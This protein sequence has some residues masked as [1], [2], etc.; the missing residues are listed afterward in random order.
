M[1]GRKDLKSGLTWALLP[2]LLALPALPA[3]GEEKRLVHGAALRSDTSPPLRELISKIPPRPTGLSVEIPLGARPGAPTLPLP[4]PAASR[5]EEPEI[6]APGATL[7]PAVLLSFPGLSDDDNSA[8][9]GG[10]F[11][12]PDTNGDIGFDH[13]GNKIYIQYINKIWG[14]F[15]PADGTLIFGPTIGNTFWSGFGGL[16]QTSNS[17]DTLVLYDDDAGRWVFA[18]FVW[19]SGGLVCVAVSA[20]G[21]PLGSY[22]RYAFQVASAGGFADYPKLGVWAQGPQGPGQGSVPTQSAYT[23]TTRNF[24]WSQ[25]SNFMHTTVLERDRMLTGSAAKF[26]S[27]P[28][29][30]TVGTDCL[31]GQLPPHQ[32][33]PP[34]PWGTCPTFFAIVDKQFDDTLFA[35]DGVRLERLCV[36]WQN[37]ANSTITET[38]LPS[39][40]G[41]SRALGDGVNACISPVKSPGE[42]L[43]CLTVFTMYRAQYRYFDGSDGNGAHASVVVNTTVDAGSQRAGIHWLELRSADGQSAWSIHQQGTYAPADARERWMGSIAQDGMRN[44]ALG[45]SRVSSSEFPSLYY[46]ARELGDAAGAMGS[47]ERCHDGTGVQTASFER[48]GDYSAM[49]VDPEDDCT[50]WFTGEYYETTGPFDFNTRICSFKV[51]NLPPSVEITM[52]TDGEEFD[53]ATSITFVGTATDVEDGDLTSSLVWTSSVDGAIG[54]GGSFMTTLSPGLHTIEASVTDSGGKP[55]IDQISLTITGS[56]CPADLD[57]VGPLV[58]NTL[59]IRRAV[60]TIDVTGDVSVVSG[61]HL[62]LLAGVRVS[63]ANGF[64]VGTGGLL[65]VETTADPCG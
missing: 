58:V 62:R 39:G 46:T 48:W 17:G 64:N 7:T 41:F 10:R 54:S 29:A 59:D 51:C 65:E 14:I 28:H 40:V 56:G 8:T 20:T 35:S 45:F 36:D 49:S 38:F 15:D 18:Q 34:P 47:E 4:P 16:C 23:L 57:I 42:P 25:G 37:T 19:P 22:H 43:D 24:P 61:G 30:C 11:V 13:Q 32:A 3:R 9:V 6:A 1:I 53:D 2:V 5:G 33:G 21:D 31:D 44:I 26:V 50:F 52:P 27:F 55:G 63:L 60:N 12:P